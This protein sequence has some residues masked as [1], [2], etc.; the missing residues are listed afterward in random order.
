MVK[1]FF[2]EQNEKIITAAIAEAESKTSGEIRVYI[3]KKAGDDPLM[4]ARYAFEKIGMR[5]TELRNGILFYLS[6]ED[7]TF[8]ILG[9]DGINEKVPARLWD[10]IKD[11]VIA[12]FIQGEFANGLSCGI[13]MAGEQLAEFYPCSKDDVNE[14]PDAIVYSDG[15]GS[16]NE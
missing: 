5:K 14:L 8:A 7:R 16:E 1:R 4:A 12:S 2:S 9:D 6:V 3:D 15:E 11:V 13:K 10:K